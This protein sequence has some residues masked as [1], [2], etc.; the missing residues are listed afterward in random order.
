MNSGS[1]VIP[2]MEIPYKADAGVFGFMSQQL[3]CARHY[4]AAREL[5]EE[6]ADNGLQC[7][8]RERKDR[9]RDAYANEGLLQEVGELPFVRLCV[10]LVR[11]QRFSVFHFPSPLPQL[12]LLVLYA[13]CCSYSILK[14]HAIL[15]P[16]RKTPCITVSYTE[17]LPGRP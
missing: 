2:G 4:E 14:M 15:F 10:G 9:N 7:D 12:L 13:G 1:C 16:L 6:K 3:W 11:R 5:H 8:I 17:N